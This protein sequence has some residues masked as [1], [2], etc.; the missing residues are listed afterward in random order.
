MLLLHQVELPHWKAHSERTVPQRRLARPR[1]QAPKSQFLSMHLTSV[2]CSLACKLPQLPRQEAVGFS[3][4][5][6]DL[7]AWHVS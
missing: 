2:G 5:Q 6:L 7:R 4:P 3:S 1:A